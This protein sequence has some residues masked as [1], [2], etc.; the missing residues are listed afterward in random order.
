MDSMVT[1]EVYTRLSGA[2]LL[3]TFEENLEG[4]MA[5]LQGSASHVSICRRQPLSDVAT[6]MNRM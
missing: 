3:H 5:E 6:Y 2:P 1:C 4:A